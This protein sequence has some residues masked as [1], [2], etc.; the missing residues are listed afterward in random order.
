M[1]RLFYKI[2]AL[3]L[4]LALCAGCVCGL[5]GCASRGVSTDDPNVENSTP[6]DQQTPVPEKEPEEILPLDCDPLT[7]AKLAEDAVQGTRPVAVMLDNSSAALPHSGIASASVIFEM[8]TEGGIP[9]LMA[10]FPSAKAIPGKLGPVRSTRDQFLQVL[11]PENM[12]L[13]HIGS[14]VYAADLLHTME[15]PTVD[16]IYLGSTVFAFDDV[17]AAAKDNS[18]CFYT[19]DELAAAGI[20]HEEIAATGTVDTLFRFVSYEKD[21]VVPAQKATNIEFSFSQIAPV[22]FAYDAET[23]R[24][25]KTEY[26]YPQM[27]E[28]TGEQVGYTNLILLECPVTLKQDGLVSH[29]DLTEGE[30]FY[31]T[32]GGWQRIGWKKGVVEQQLTLY[33]EAGDELAVNVGTSYVA[34]VGDRTLKATLALDSLS[35]Y[36]NT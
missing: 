35:P 23:N 7:G 19:N 3:T 20:A 12:I 15:Y 21:P 16:G 8:V 6:A 25:L 2:L 30:G 10:V 36:D 33:D 14:S 31:F 24:Y 34:V 29:F 11:I 1:K 26:G 32:Q 27:D 13:L 4:C 9:R 28:A 22:R 5:G 18:H 17:R